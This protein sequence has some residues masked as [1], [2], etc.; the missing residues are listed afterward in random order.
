MH[1]HN[2]YAL[3]RPNT[4]EDAECDM[5]KVQYDLAFVGT[6]F[7]PVSF[8]IFLENVRWSFRFQRDPKLTVDMSW[9]LHNGEDKKGLGDEP[10]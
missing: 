10:L 5:I 1:A 9:S 8:E 4:A 3:K 6:T 7:A 2:P